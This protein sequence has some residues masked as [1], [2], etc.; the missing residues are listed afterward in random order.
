MQIPAWA[1]KLRLL[2][3][4]QGVEVRLRKLGRSEAV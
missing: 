2:V 3:G 1:A 4:A